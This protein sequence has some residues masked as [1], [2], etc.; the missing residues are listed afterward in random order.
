MT[1]QVGVIKKDLPFNGTK[2]INGTM[3]AWIGILGNGGFHRS[4]PPIPSSPPNILQDKYG[5]SKDM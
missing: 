3:D 2:I 5:I 4:H 1:D